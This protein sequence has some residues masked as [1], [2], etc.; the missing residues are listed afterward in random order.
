MKTFH[1]RLFFHRAFRY[2]AGFILLLF[3]FSVLRYWTVYKY[4]PHRLVKTTLEK[5]QSIDNQEN[6]AIHRMFDFLLQK[7]TPSWKQLNDYVSRLEEDM[8]DLRVIRFFFGTVIVFLCG[9]PPAWKLVRLK[10]CFLAV[11]PILH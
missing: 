9:M 6:T 8:V 4:E 5:I 1:H 11:V 2:F 7:N 3:A 10:S